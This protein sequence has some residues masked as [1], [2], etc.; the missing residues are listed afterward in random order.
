MKNVY[1]YIC[2]RLNLTEFI[3]SRKSK[4]VIQIVHLLKIPGIFGIRVSDLFPI[5]FEIPGIWIFSREIELPKK[6]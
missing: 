5:G 3:C 2:V 4:R 6:N 1:Q